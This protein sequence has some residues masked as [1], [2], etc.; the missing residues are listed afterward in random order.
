VVWE[1]GAV[2]SSPLPDSEH[3]VLKECEHFVLKECEHFGL[4]ANASTSPERATYLEGTMSQSLAKILV[5]LIFSTKNRQPLIHDDIRDELHAYLI[6]ILQVYESPSLITNSE[7]DHAHIL[8]S[9]SKK[10][11]LAE[12]VEEV[13]KGSSKWIKTKGRSYANFYW[14]GGYGAFA[15]SESDRDQV[16]QY[17][18]NQHEHHKKVTFQ[19][20]LRTLL[21]LNGIEFD[22]RYLWD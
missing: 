21:T 7:P 19:D 16:I 14:Q 3:F 17:I 8:F 12:I 2:R 10:H 4:K 20:E 9:L 18:A 6:G 22:E 13:K 5:H 1:G 11:A 15:V